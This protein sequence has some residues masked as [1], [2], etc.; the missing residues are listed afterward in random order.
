VVKDPE[1]RMG[2]YAYKDRQWVSYDDVETIR[3]KEW[4]IEAYTLIKKKRN[5]SSYIGKFRM[6]RLQSHI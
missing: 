4:G 6:E 1:G 3:R 5:F 2:P